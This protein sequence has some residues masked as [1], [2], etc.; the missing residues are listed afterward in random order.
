M[1]RYDAIS[2]DYFNWMYDRV[3]GD[4]FRNQMSYRKLLKYLYDR[5]FVFLDRMDEN[6]AIDGVDLRYRHDKETAR[7]LSDKP[8]S[9]LE[10]MIAL[11]IRCE[12][13]IMS[14]MKYGDRTNKWFWGMIGN[15]SLHNMSDSEFNIRMVRHRIDILLR[16]EY[17]PD[18][19]G[20][21]FTVKHC[22]YDLTNVEI[23]YQMNWYL[24]SIV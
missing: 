9:V 11:S 4:S 1:T 22:S 14:D 8:C 15:M 17:D 18:G 20:G 21:L 19:R 7:E 23:W 12:N 5:D 6:R 24:N 16:R 2:E 3:C 10:M 13:D